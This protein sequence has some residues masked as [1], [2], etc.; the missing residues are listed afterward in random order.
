MI[1]V[2]QTMWIFILVMPVLTEMVGTGL[3][4]SIYLFPFSPV[5]RIFSRIFPTY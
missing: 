4:M 1:V 3:I 2:L 5:I